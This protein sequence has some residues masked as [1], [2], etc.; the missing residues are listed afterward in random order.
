[1][2]V[3]RNSATHFKLK[4]GHHER[5]E[6]QYS[7]YHGKN[8]SFDTLSWKTFRLHFH[9]KLYSIQNTLQ[10][11][12]LTVEEQHVLS[13]GNSINWNTILLVQK[14]QTASGDYTFTV[15]FADEKSATFHQNSP[16]G[17]VLLN[18]WEKY[19]PKLSE[20]AERIPIR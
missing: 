6:A 18:H 19:A 9:H 20:T 8:R 13:A 14:M 15:Y 7:L 4:M 2:N 16:E 12:R 17:A 10:K 1:M 11:V 5:L 3:Y